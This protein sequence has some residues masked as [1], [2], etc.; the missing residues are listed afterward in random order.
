MDGDK[1]VR[2][3]Q[4]A[5]IAVLGVFVMSAS[6]QASEEKESAALRAAEEWLA[7]VDAE[8]YGESWQAA[9]SYFQ[10]AVS[11][12]QWQQALNGVRR[13]LGTVLSRRPK[14]KTFTTT[15]PGAPDGQ[16]V[17]IQFDTSF[18]NKRSSVETV[19]PMLDENGRWRVSGYFIK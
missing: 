12:D 1:I 19:T 17:V 5:T 8:R 15:L 3:V 11:R 10:K 4:L 13:P 18:E 7:L 6:G 14:S 16:Y 9:A 2:A